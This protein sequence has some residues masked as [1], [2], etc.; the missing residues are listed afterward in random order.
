MKS[1]VRLTGDDS[2]VTTIAAEAVRVLRADPQTAAALFHRLWDLHGRRRRFVARASVR[3]DAASPGAPKP[4]STPVPAAAYR[5]LWGALLGVGLAAALTSAVMLGPADRKNAFTDPALALS[6]AHIA[7][8]IAIPLLLIALI[9]RV[10][11][12]RSARVGVTLSVLVGSVCAG[13]LVFRVVAGGSDDR[14][15]GAQD[16]AVWMPM[17]AVSVLLIAAIAVR[18][19]LARR[20]VVATARHP[21]STR[22]A[23]REMLREAEWIASSGRGS[24]QLDA[25]W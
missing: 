5:A 13:I 3:A 23:A 10:P 15:F 2:D 19:D 16:V 24:A 21:R 20:T 25:E 12:P 8:T 7:G 14:G 18:C 4:V 9:L 11:D 6:V 22:D 17:T 1:A